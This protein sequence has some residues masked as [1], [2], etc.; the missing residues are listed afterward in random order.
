MEGWSGPRVADPWW[1]MH[2]VSMFMVKHDHVWLPDTR[3]GQ[4]DF[5]GDNLCF[6][7]IFSS[8]GDFSLKFL[9]GQFFIIFFFLSPGFTGLAVFFALF[10][11]SC[12][13]DFV[14]HV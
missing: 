6:G 9:V 7:F 5:L 2:W 3:R 1:R 8:S 13:A 10:Q 14:G 4:V 12:W 11:S